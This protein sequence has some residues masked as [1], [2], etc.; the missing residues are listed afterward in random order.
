VYSLGYSQR[1]WMPH[2]CSA[3]VL[4]NYQM[5]FTPGEAGAIVLNSVLPVVLSRLG[6]RSPIVIVFNVLTSTI[7]AGKA[8]IQ[9]LLLDTSQR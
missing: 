6:T 1:F 7:C 9:Q 2:G 3:R 5:A 4:L 8:H